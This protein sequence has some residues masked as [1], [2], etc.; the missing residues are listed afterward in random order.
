MLQLE[1]QGRLEAKIPSQTALPLAA[2]TALGNAVCLVTQPLRD[3]SL[4]RFQRVRPEAAAE[5][6]LLQ[7]QAEP[8]ATAVTLG[9]ELE[10]RAPPFF[11][12]VV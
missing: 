4:F 1:P 11:P 5:K 12:R 9:C 10:S 7:G 2:D 3:G 8:G 6:P